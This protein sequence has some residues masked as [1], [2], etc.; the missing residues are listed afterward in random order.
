MCVSVSLLNPI[1]GTGLL[2]NVTQDC[3]NEQIIM[4]AVIVAVHTFLARVDQNV[5]FYPY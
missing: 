4:Y 1:I 3:Q 5:R 2:A